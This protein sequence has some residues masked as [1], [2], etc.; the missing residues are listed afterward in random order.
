MTYS[1]LENLPSGY[2]VRAG[3]SRDLND[4]LV[5]LDERVV[6][7]ADGVETIEVRVDMTGRPRVFLRLGDMRPEP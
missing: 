7:A 3:A 6:D 1:R 5:P 4:W 2:G